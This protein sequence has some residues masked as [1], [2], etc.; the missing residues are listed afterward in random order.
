MPGVVPASTFA[1][2]DHDGNFH[3]R[4]AEID[5][6]HPV[7]SERWIVGTRPQAGSNLTAVGDPH[8]FTRRNLIFGGFAALGH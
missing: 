1:A 5:A 3:I 8:L 6:E 7:F 4:L 2:F